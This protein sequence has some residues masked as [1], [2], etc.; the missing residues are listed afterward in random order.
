MWISDV[1]LNPRIVF[2][3]N[4]PSAADLARMHDQAH[5]ACFIANSITSKVTIA[6][7]G[8]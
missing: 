2:A 4:P 3:G 8:D 6:M 7:A 5:E 1:K